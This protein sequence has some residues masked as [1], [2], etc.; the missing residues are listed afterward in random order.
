[1]MVSFTVESVISLVIVS[2]MINILMVELVMPA[3]P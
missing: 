3:P 1:M 2:I